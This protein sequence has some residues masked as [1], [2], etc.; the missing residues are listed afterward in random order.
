MSTRLIYFRRNGCPHCHTLDK[1]WEKII[2][3]K[4][5]Q[6]LVECKKI[7]FDQHF[8]HAVN[9]DPP[10]NKIVTYRPFIWLENTKKKDEGFILQDWLGEK[11]RT[12]ESIKEWI[13]KFT[14]PWGLFN[15][16]NF[17]KFP[18]EVR[19]EILCFLLCAKEIKLC[20][21]LRIVIIEFIATKR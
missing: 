20:A 16:G 13:C 9:F 12:Y 17:K 18:E 8:K 5:L 3:D 19:Q 6:K 4:Y 2:R 1:E 10:F 14:I 21:D 15:K 11:K 7:E